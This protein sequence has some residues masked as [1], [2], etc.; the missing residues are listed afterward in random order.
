MTK[1]EKV[2]PEKE[3]IWESSERLE[4]G[5]WAGICL[6]NVNCGGTVLTPCMCKNIWRVVNLN[7]EIN[8]VKIKVFLPTP[9]SYRIWCL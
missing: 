1:C 2:Q 7:H 5:M 8:I 6:A 3:F 4:A 9:Y